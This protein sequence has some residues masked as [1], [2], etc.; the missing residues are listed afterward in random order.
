MS[1]RRAHAAGLSQLHCSSCG[2]MTHAVRVDADRRPLAD[3]LDCGQTT[4]QP[5]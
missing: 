4:H 1:M 2:G 5:R 3:C